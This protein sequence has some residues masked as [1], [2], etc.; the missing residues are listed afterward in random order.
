[1]D[2]LAFIHTNVYV[3][4]DI[5]GC[6]WCCEESGGKISRRCIGPPRHAAGVFCFSLLFPLLNIVDGETASHPATSSGPLP[7]VQGQLQHH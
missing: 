3:R 7:P 6:I 5:G 4:I 2:P 1:M